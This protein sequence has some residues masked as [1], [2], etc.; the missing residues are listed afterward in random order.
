MSNDERLVTVDERQL[1]RIWALTCALASNEDHNRRSLDSVF[2]VAARFVSR[3]DEGLATPDG[4]ELDSGKAN[5]TG[6]K[7]LYRLRK[8]R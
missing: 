5:P 1:D 7:V 6:G 4:I 3:I 2:L 8:R